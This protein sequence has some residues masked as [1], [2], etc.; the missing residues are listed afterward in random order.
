ME[1]HNFKHLFHTKYNGHTF[2]ESDHKIYSW[3]LNIICEV[4]KIKG[5]YV[6]PNEYFFINF[7]YHDLSCNECLIKNIIE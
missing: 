5:N 4:C 1:K 3:G 6:E 7:K 2:I